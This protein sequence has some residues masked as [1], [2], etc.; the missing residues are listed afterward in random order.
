MLMYQK[1]IKHLLN[2]CS[3][4]GTHTHNPLKREE[5]DADNPVCVSYTGILAYGSMVDLEGG[6]LESE[7]L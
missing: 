7:L 1:S 3:R 5:G 4:V 6:F 2:Q